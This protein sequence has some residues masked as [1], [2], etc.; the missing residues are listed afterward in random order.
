MNVLGIN[1][2]LWILVFGVMLSYLLMAMPLPEILRM[3]RPNLVLLAMLYWLW[4]LPEQVGPGGAF[5]LGFL[6][7]GFSGAPLGLHAFSFASIAALLLL[8]HR[9]W[10]MFSLL[11][12]AFLV[13]FLLWL[14]QLIQASGQLAYRQ[15]EHHLWVLASSILGGVCWV[16]L[17]H[18][19]Y[20]RHWST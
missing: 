6:Y 9:R 8:F 19:S 10:Q 2:R 15:L 17:N 4:R 12:Q 11:Q 20:T 16:L 14:D 3:L 5:L 7:D 1:R 13:I 18:S